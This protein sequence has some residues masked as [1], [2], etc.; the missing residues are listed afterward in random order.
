MNSCS[1]MDISAVH[2]ST[3]ELSSGGWWHVHCIQGINVVCTSLCICRCILHALKVLHQAGYAHTDLRWENII[4]Q[5]ADQWVLID[6]E[7]ACVL[8]SVPF[9]PVGEPMSCVL[10]IGLY[11]LS[12][13]LQNAFRKPQSKESKMSPEPVVSRVLSQNICILSVDMVLC[14]HTLNM[15]QVLDAYVFKKFAIQ[16]GRNCADYRTYQKGAARVV[17][18]TVVKKL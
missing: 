12:A 17:H 16:G 15:L 18:S 2:P 13:C 10:V 1:S 9:T 7:F 4:L 11:C 8:N 5:H 6:L 14:V 3:A